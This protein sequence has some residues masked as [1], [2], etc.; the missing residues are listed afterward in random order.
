MLSSVS[1]SVVV[2]CNSHLP[3][4]AFLAGLVIPRQGGLAIGLVEKL[5][6]MV[7]IIFLPLVRFFFS[8]CCLENNR[9]K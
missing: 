8:F 2:M 5:E 4:G 7:S 3:V 9:T 1:Y 6:D